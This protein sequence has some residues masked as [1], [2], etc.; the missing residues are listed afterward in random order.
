[1]SHEKLILNFSE[2]ENLFFIIYINNSINLLIYLNYNNYHW[3]YFSLQAEISKRKKKKTWP[4][5]SILSRIYWYTDLILARSHG[6]SFVVRCIDNYS[7][8][9]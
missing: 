2:G 9:G 1:M 8:T 7:E 4:I 6:G 3:N 5:C